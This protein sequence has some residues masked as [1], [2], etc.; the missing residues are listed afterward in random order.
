MPYEFT[1]D[2]IELFWS[3]VDRSG[4]A[5]ACWLWT[6]GKDKDGYGVV[7]PGGRKGRLQYAHRV[8]FFVTHG[9]WPQPCCLH[10][11]DTPA[12]VNPTHL[13][14]GT[15]RDNIRDRDRKGR[16]ARGER[17]GISKL[18]EAQVREIR[19]RHASGA[20]YKQLALDYGV[21]R[22]LIWPIVNRK[23]WKHV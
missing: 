6:R 14:E 2:D 23:I 9:R 18:T 19:E 22:S 3:R 21:N 13:F 20:T 7:Q 12:C 11:C 16:N 1:P 17:I 5:D 10:S 4:G 8:A 15:N